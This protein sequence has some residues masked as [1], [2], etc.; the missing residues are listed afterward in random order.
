MAPPVP[1]TFK[2]QGNNNHRAAGLIAGQSDDDEEPASM[3]E[4]DMEDMEEFEAEEAAL[5]MDQ[6]EDGP[7]GGVGGRGGGKLNGGRTGRQSAPL[8]ITAGGDFKCSVC[9]FTTRSRVTL[10]RHERL[11]HLKKKFFRCVKCNYVTHVKARYTKHVKYH[12]M[13]M[14]KCDLCEFRTPYKWNL[15]RH[16]KNHMGGGMYQC[17]LCNFTAHIKQSLTVHIQN[18][19]LS[20]DKARSARRRNKVGASDQLNEVSPAETAMDADEAELLRLERM[21]HD[22]RSQGGGLR[23]LPDDEDDDEGELE[24]VDHHEMGEELASSSSKADREEFGFLHPDDLTQKNGRLYSTG[25]SR[26]QC[27]QYKPMVWG[28]ADVMRQPAGKVNGET[29]TTN[30]GG[31]QMSP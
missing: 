17:S 18:H 5:M 21:E 12:S 23:P 11:T 22:A 3:P 15:D 16:L 6:E 26:S 28:D 7:G 31:G 9:D 20:P 13:P 10:Q 24:G 1:S 30:V 29:K 4:E 19:H 14:I 2:S 25:R 8:P 27:S